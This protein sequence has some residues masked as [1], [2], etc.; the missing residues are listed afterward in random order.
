MAHK[1]SHLC[2]GFF[3]ILI[4]NSEAVLH[5]TTFSTINRYSNICILIHL[6]TLMGVEWEQSI[7]VG[8]NFHLD[9]FLWW[10]DTKLVSYMVWVPKKIAWS[11]TIF[12]INR[13]FANNF[14]YLK[15]CKCYTYSQQIFFNFLF[16]QSILLCTN[17]AKEVIQFLLR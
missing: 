4:H 6:Y 11:W 1:L 17:M 15:L 5:F 10:L 7:K 16:V 3:Y 13:N 12:R 8:F 14:K 9:F 2:T